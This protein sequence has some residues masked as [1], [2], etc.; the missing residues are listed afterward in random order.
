[1][2]TIKEKKNV[3]KNTPTNLLSDNGHALW[4]AK[5]NADSNSSEQSDK[6]HHLKSQ[7]NL[8]LM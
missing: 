4:I 7:C 3:R 2:A 6:V 8:Y 5:T 1:M